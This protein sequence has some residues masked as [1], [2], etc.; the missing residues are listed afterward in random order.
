MR[1]KNQ[2]TM[3]KILRYVEQYTLEYH[4]T[5]TLRNIADEVGVSYVTVRSYLQEMNEN[6]IIHYDGKNIESETISK[7]SGVVLARLVGAVSCGPLELSEES[8]ESILSLPESLIGKG[9]FFALR[10]SGDSMIKSGINHGDIVIVKQDVEPKKGDIV[11]ALDDNG[12]TTLKRY[13][14][15][16][17]GCAIL[18]P[19]N[20]TMEDIVVHGKLSCQG[21]AVYV[22]KDLSGI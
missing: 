5:P 21:R 2:D 3:D 4:R 15:I 6:G 20:D 9:K 8:T 12:Q 14:G 19:E 17:N 7:G 13:L 16:K 10:A 11:V 18:H 1:Q 22:M